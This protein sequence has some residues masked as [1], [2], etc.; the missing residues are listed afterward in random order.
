MSKKQEQSNSQELE[1]TRANEEKYQAL[2]S[3]VSVRCL[4]LQVFAGRENA[5]APSIRLVRGV[6]FSHRN[7]LGWGLVET[8]ISTS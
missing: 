6:V 7:D 2:I 4:G 5:E 3:Q 8:T 1:I